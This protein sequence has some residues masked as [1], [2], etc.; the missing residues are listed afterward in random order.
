M[1]TTKRIKKSITENAEDR[2][3]RS[4]LSGPVDFI[5]AVILGLIVVIMFVQVIFRYT[6]N[7][8]LTWSEEVVRFLFIWLNFLGASILIRDKWHIGVDFFVDLLPGHMKKRMQLL[9]IILIVCFLVFLSISGFFWMYFTRGTVSSALRL[10]LNI[11]LYGALPVTSLIG[12]LYGI[13]RIRKE[14]IKIGKGAHRL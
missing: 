12:I 11:M 14:L 6:F 13:G 1:H 9:D 5:L 7:D 10:P 4:S 8:S 3:R 2:D